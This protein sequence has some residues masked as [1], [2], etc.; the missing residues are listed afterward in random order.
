MVG[1]CRSGRPQDLLRQ[2]PGFHQLGEFSAGGCFGEGAH[3][4]GVEGAGVLPGGS[5]HLVH[6]R[7][8]LLFPLGEGAR[9]VNGTHR[10][11]ERFF[12]RF[13]GLFAPGSQAGGEDLPR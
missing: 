4:L 1:L 5:V 13:P 6:L 12:R 10:R 9:N 11:R 2:Q 7:D 8:G 3:L